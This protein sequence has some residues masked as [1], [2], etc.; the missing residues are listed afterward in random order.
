M[1]DML[2]LLVCM[3]SSSHR[4]HYEDKDRVEDDVE[5]RTQIK[6]FITYYVPLVS[7]F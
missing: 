1:G 7:H 6:E 4:S 2:V 5:L 3:Y